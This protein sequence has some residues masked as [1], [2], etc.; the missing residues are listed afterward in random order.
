[1]ILREKEITIPKTKNQSEL[2]KYFSQSVE[3]EIRADEKLIRFAVT[4]TDEENHH[5]ELGM[6]SEIPQSFHYA[7]GS[8][9]NFKKRG[10][11]NNNTFNAALI[12]PTGIGAEIGGHSGDAGSVA[13]LIASACDTLITHPNVVN[14]SDIME[15]PENGLYVEGSVLSRFLMGTAGLQKVNRNDVLFVVDEDG[16]TTDDTI[17]MVSA[18]RACLGMECSVV[19]MKDTIKMESAYTSSGRATGKIGNLE[20]LCKNI[21]DHVGN[22]DAI[23]LSTK[24][25]VEENVQINYYKSGG[26]IINPWGGAEAMLTHFVS[27]A[28]N[29]PSAHSPFIPYFDLKA[30]IIDPRI[31]AEEVSITFLFCILKGLNKSPKIISD[32][33]LFCRPEVMTASDVSCIIIPY[34]C[35]GL[36]T[37]AAIEH[38]IPVIAVKENKNIMKNSLED[39]P[40]S[41]N[42]LFVVENYWEAVGIMH[43][44]KSGVSPAAVRRPLAFTDVTRK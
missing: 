35:I 16:D 37:L 36:P 38:G 40:F 32:E 29:L 18:A 28:F 8:I 22:F 3:K 26:E 6:V 7:G 9:F 43:A 20:S 13:R 12:I 2:L 24:M 11:E 23:A 15:L 17:N 42:K 4:S 41:R 19:T 25:E 44:L 33:K 21:A 14:A 1:M 27:S 39:L 31:A 30:G 34:G 10:S 5:C